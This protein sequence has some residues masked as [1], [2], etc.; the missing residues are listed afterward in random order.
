MLSFLPNAAQQATNDAAFQQ[1][2]RERTVPIP[3]TIT[4]VPGEVDPEFGT[5]V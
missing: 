4:P 1:Q 2:P 3:T 5:G